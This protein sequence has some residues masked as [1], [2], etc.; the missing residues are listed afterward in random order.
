MSAS[1]ATGVASSRPPDIDLIVACLPPILNREVVLAAAAAG[2]HV[3][4]EKPLAESAEVATSSSMPAVP[5]A[6]STVSPRP[7]GGTRPCERSAP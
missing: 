2:K 4:C 5:R 3:V 7:T 1:I 6:C